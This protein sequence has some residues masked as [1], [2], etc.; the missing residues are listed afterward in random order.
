MI[1][2]CLAGAQGRMGRLLQ[3]LIAA[4]DD[5]ALGAALERPDHPDLGRELAPGVR[6]GAEL[7]KA[8]LGADVLL[9]FSPPGALVAHIQAAAQ[10]GRPAVSGT[11]GLSGAEL[12]A[13]RAAAHKIPVAHSAN[14]S[15]SVHA[16]EQLVR[17]ASRLLGPEV[18]VEIVETHHKGKADAPSGTALLLA[19]A[20]RSVRGGEAIYARSAKRKPGEIGLAAIRGGDVVGEHDVLFLGPGERLVVAHRA[21]TREHFC[22]GALDAVRFVRGRTSGLYSAADVFGEG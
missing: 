2:I 11:T 3:E 14:W 4:A 12:E 6:L 18:D 20:V 5:L 10:A 15:R 1:R 16:L 7:A 21:T 19:E 13:I 17:L 22:R 9:D 8:L